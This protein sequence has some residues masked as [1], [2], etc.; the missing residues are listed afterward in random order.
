MARLKPTKPVSAGPKFPMTHYAQLYQWPLSTVH[1]YKRKGYPLDDPEKLLKVVQSTKHTRE[2]IEALQQVVRSR[3]TVKSQPAP[4]PP[5][6]APTESGPVDA[7]DGM[8][9]ELRRLKTE[10]DQAYE[11]YRQ[12]PSAIEKSG[13]WKLWQ[14]LLTV[15][16][17]MAKVAPEAEREA[18]TVAR[19]Q[20]VDKTWSR[21]F[22]EVKSL[23]EGLPRRVATNPKLKKYDPVDIEQACLEELARVFT[24]LQSG[25]W[26]PKS[27]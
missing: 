22:Q 23:L 26:L 9:L 7:L 15:W 6:S 2:H 13:Y 17:R 1:S 21:T 25:S 5:K 11:N 18:G 4:P 14:E 19:V 24:V 12:A 16:S 27:K 3:R 10:T 20:D 8:Q